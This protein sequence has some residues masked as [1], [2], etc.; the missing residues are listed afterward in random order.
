[1]RIWVARD[2]NPAPP[3]LNKKNLQ[4]VE[5]GS[6]GGALLDSGGSHVV[7]GVLF[8][9]ISQLSIC[10]LEQI[11]NFNFLLMFNIDAEKYTHRKCIIC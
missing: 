9:G 5:L 4:V 1:M 11:F 7:I 3:S 8:L 6:A 10:N 2:R